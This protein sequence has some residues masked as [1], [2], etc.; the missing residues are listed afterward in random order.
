MF[1]VFSLKISG[2][3]RYLSFR[4]NV[5]YMPRKPTRR[6]FILSGLALPLLLFVAGCGSKPQN[7]TFE[8]AK[9]DST[10]RSVSN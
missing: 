8:E 4:L 1:W 7:I 9:R 5:E 3:T 6:D 10:K 2:V